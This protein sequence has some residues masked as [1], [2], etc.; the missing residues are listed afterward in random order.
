M[1]SESVDMGF[2]D[3]G[4]VRLPEHMRK[5]AKFQYARAAEKTTLAA[6]TKIRGW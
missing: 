2:F 4:A 6:P 5:C 1:P 3:A